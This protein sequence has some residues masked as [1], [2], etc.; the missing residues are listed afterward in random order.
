MPFI[1]W[2]V[3]DEAVDLMLA[4]MDAGED[5]NLEKSRDMGASWLVIALLDWCFLFKR[6]FNAGLVSRKES[7]VDSR[8]D[9]DSLFEKVRYI[10]DHLPPWM[11]P[12]IRTRYM[13]L[14]NLELNSTL[15]GES[16][17]A[18]VGRGGRKSVY[19][20]DEAAAILNGEAIESALS[21]N[22]I[23]QIW[24][25]TPKGPMTQFHKRIKEKRGR[26]LQMP[27][28]RHPEKAQFAKQEVDVNGKI[29][30]T[31]PWY[32]KQCEKYSRKTIA[33]EIDI[34]HGQ[35]GDIFF[36]YNEL[37]RHRRDHVRPPRFVGEIRPVNA[38]DDEEE[39][40]SIMQSNEEDYCFV[41]GSSRSY[42]RFWLDLVHNRP[43]QQ[44]NYVFG[45]DIANGAG[46]S[47]SVITVL[48]REINQVVAKYWNAYV[49]PEELA[50]LAAMAGIWFGGLGSAA[51][52][53]WENN[54]PGG[55]LGRKLVK[56]GYPNYYRQRQTQTHK[57]RRTP[58]WGWH[59]NNARKEELLGNYRDW[60]SRDAIINPCQESLDEAGDYIYD[61]SG[62]LI[63]ALLRE[64]TAGGRHLHGD[65]VIADALTIIGAEELP[66][67]RQRPTKVPRGSYQWRR[68]Q[69]QKKLSRRK[70]LD[71]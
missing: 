10:H 15:A 41:K 56:L 61:D 9:M 12:R 18:D 31:S 68:Q 28:W 27:W 8:G 42:W 34:D 6:N 25:S 14:H 54:G 17:N 64:E 24:A 22:T 4:C 52:I 21:Q 66:M 11:L 65:H 45:I 32:L 50:R 40:Q 30:W 38:L 53:V 2:S 36:D 55:I 71:W 20:V 7:L 16:T 51:F 23:C 47:N 70:K 13:H 67:N 46:D 57:D 19:L 58:R 39:V 3:Q 35:A 59:N 33:Q 69:H 37:E 5:V 60:L 1:T 44:Y 62:S 49:S 43:P 26:R 48:A 29:V 63:P